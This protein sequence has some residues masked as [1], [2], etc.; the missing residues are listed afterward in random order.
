MVLKWKLLK[1]LRE[2]CIAW[3][4]R[5]NIKKVRPGE[6]R[7]KWDFP[8]ETQYSKETPWGTPKTYPNSVKSHKWVI[9]DPKNTKKARE[10][11]FEEIFKKWYTLLLGPGKTE[12]LCNVKENGCVNQSERP[13]KW[14]RRE[15]RTN[16]GIRSPVFKWVLEYRYYRLK[17]DSRLTLVFFIPKWHTQGPV[18][19][20]LPIQP[21]LPCSRTFCHQR[22]ERG[23]DQ[24]ERISRDEE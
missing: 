11:C 3:R 13:R 21:V 8:R 20:R 12:D 19:Q 14:L 18:T 24:L 2:W 4:D 7:H 5:I 10:P 15:V 17:V 1:K 6:K 9:H 22:A 16:R 23:G